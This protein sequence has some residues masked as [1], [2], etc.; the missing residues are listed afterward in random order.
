[1]KYTTPIVQITETV[2]T[3]ADGCTGSYQ[4]GGWFETFNCAAGRFSCAS[5]AFACSKYNNV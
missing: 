1:M 4:C 2:I 3:R 5:G